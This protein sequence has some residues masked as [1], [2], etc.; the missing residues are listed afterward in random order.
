MGHDGMAVLVHNITV[1]CALLRLRENIH[2]CVSI[3]HTH[4]HLICSH[5]NEIS[6]T[7]FAVVLFLDNLSRKR[8]RNRRL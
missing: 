3:T 7:V 1:Y 4:H 6:V 8:E 2:S 5:L